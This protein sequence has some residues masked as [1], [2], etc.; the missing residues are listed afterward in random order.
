[1]IGSFSAVSKPIFAGKY[2]FSASFSVYTSCARLNRSKLNILANNRFTKPAIFVKFQQNIFANLANI[3]KILPNC[4]MS[5]R[6]SRRSKKMLKSA[7]LLAKI[8]ADTAENEPNFAKNFQNNWQRPYPLA[9]EAEE[10]LPKLR[11]GRR[12]DRT[13]ATATLGVGSLLERR[14]IK[15]L[16]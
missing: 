14:R 5:A 8:G 13:R 11:L 16:L 6:Q 12:A 10:Q 1:L 4:K 15:Y 7:Y 3:C 2:A 9:A